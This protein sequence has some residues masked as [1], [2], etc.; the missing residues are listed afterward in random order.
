MPSTVL[1]KGR[2]EEEGEGKTPKV[3]M[4]INKKKSSN[5]IKQI[6]GVIGSSAKNFIEQTEKP[7]SNKNS[8]PQFEN[9]AQ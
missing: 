8:G 6:F 9:S 3:G 4:M 5:S 7:L 1:G 2:G